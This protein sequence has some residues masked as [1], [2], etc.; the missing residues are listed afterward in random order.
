MKRAA[1]SKSDRAWELV[2]EKLMRQ[3]KMLVMRYNFRSRSWAIKMRKR[4][5]T[6]MLEI[7]KKMILRWRMISKETCIQRKKKMRDKVNVRVSNRKWMNRWEMLMK[8]R[9]KRT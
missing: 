6:K 4:M 1:V 5:K 8:S 3:L 2:R 7:K 9:K